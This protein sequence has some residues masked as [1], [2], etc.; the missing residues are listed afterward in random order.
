MSKSAWRARRV[1]LRAHTL[2]GSCQREA[3][4]LPA[5]AVARGGRG[6]AGD[7]PALRGNAAPPAERYLQ[8]ARADFET[9]DGVGAHKGAKRGGKA[10]KGRAACGSSA[11]GWSATPAVPDRLVACDQKTSAP[12]GVTRHT[13]VEAGA[14]VV[15]AD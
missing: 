1:S 4:P 8:K 11:R 15:T 5:A 7:S 13:A 10:A 6:G 9:Q 14:G 2:Q 3:A 12:L